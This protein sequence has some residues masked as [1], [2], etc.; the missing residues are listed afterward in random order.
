MTRDQMN[1]DNANHYRLMVHKNM[2]TGDVNRGYYV[3]V[4]AHLDGRDV[5]AVSQE[6]GR[7]QNNE[8][9]KNWIYSSREK[10]EITMWVSPMMDCDIEGWKIADY[11]DNWT[12]QLYDVFLMEIVQKQL[13]NEIVRIRRESGYDEKEAQSI[14]EADH[15]A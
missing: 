10:A 9:F 7:R 8:D 14:A 12:S 15:D 6:Y 11:P 4:S 13:R 3:L 1:T 5:E 2:S